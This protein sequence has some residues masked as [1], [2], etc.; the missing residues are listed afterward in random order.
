MAVTMNV[1]AWSALL[2]LILGGHALLR[3]CAIVLLAVGPATPQV[4]GDK[5]EGK[6][7]RV[8][9]TL[10]SDS[11]NDKKTGAASKTYPYEMKAGKAYAI[12]MTSTEVDAYLRLEDAKGNQLAENDDDEP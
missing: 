7:F 1:S 5:G 2:F 3:P 9:G 10:T 6:E 4:A 11:P 8:E 12:R